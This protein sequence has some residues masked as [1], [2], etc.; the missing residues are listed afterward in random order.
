MGWGNYIVLEGLFYDPSV[1]FPGKRLTHMGNTCSRQ[2][3]GPG[4]P[5][6]YVFRLKL[7]DLAQNFSEFHL[8][9]GAGTSAG[10]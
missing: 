9:N 1:S 8:S 2:S 7:K 4:T 3:V 10:S 5:Q 6:R